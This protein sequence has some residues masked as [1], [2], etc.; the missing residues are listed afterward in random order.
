MVRIAEGNGG[1]MVSVTT[2]PAG[3]DV[4]HAYVGGEPHQSDDS[5]R[6]IADGAGKWQMDGWKS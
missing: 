3:K 1:E 5:D 4:Q 2:S 6:T